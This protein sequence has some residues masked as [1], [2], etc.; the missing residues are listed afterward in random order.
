MK[1][2][3]FFIF[4]SI[5]FIGFI[6]GCKKNDGGVNT[7]PI[8]PI[9]PDTIPSG[10]VKIKVDTNGRSID[11]V[12]FI[13]NSVGYASGFSG[14]LKSIDGGNTW[15]K[16]SGFQMSNISVTNDGSAFF[17]GNSNSVIKTIDGGVSFIDKIVGSEIIKD[18]FFSNNSTGLVSSAYGLFLT[19]NAGNSWSAVFNNS[20]YKEPTI[21]MFDN[22]HAWAVYGNRIVHANVNLNT[23]QTDTLIPQTTNMSL[24]TVWATSPNTVFTSSYSGYLYKSTNGGSSFSFLQKLNPGNFSSF[25]DLCFIDSN[26]GFISVGSRIYKTTDAGNSWQM[27]LALGNTSIIEIHFT[28]ATHGWACCND[29]TI[30]K[31]N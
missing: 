21:F 24:I 29:G 16:I 22:T 25:S 27:I 9:L 17:V 20:E 10:W 5:L 13:N 7:T 19:T 2:I 26:T 12:F 23:W 18:V 15:A 31:L 8:V 3:K 30:L 4:I 14:I 28:D 1:T 6:T 11:D